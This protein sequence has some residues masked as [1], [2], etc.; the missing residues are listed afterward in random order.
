MGASHFHVTS[1]DEENG[2]WAA[3]PVPRAAPFGNDAEYWKSGAGAD[4]WEE[5]RAQTAAGLTNVE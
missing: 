3:A 1:D 2:M 5:L 4:V